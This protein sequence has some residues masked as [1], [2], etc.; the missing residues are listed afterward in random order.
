MLSS[1]IYTFAFLSSF[2]RHAGR[3]SLP[4][5]HVLFC[6]RKITEK[7]RERMMESD[8]LPSRRVLPHF[9]PHTINDNEQSFGAPSAN[10]DGVATH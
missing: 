3:V 8:T 7:P 5:L 10:D 1:V 9:F 4:I 2:G 6:D